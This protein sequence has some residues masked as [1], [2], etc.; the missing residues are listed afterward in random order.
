MKS[1]AVFVIML[2][3]ILSVNL[4][5]ADDKLIFV[6]EEYPPY[7]YLQDGMATGMDIKIIDAI[8]KKAGLT[9][10]IKFYPW[11]R[12][13]RMAKEGKADVIFGL[14]KNTERLGFLKYPDLA[15]NYD[16]RVLIS[17]KTYPERIKNIQDLKGKTIGVVRGYSYGDEFDNNT[18]FNRD[19]S[20]TSGHLLDKF[21]SKRYDLIAINEYVAKFL[22]SELSWSNYKV[23]PYIITNGLLYS[24][25]SLKSERAMNSFK[26]YNDALNA[27]ND[28]GELNRIRNKYR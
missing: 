15:I 13:I 8:C 6:C 3:L 1:I 14:L 12:C 25:F 20:V 26:R 11:E 2:G 4:L 22:I 21:N 19:F 16:K 10:E 18:S 17:L 23:H 27:I 7:E 9:Y 5:Y 28:S 24:A